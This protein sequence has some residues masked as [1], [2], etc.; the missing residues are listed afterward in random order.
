MPDSQLL[1]LQQN[2]AK[3]NY[4]SCNGFPSTS[5]TAKAA[6]KQSPAPQFKKKEGTAGLRSIMATQK[7]ISG[8]TLC[9]INYW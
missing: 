6:R 1:S 8:E 7:D 2:H 9:L 5:A 3:H 4:P